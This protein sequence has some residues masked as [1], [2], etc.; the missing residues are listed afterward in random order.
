MTRLVWDQSG[1]KRYYTGLDR[2]VLY[3]P[4]GSAV[5]WN[6]LIAVEEDSSDI[7]VESVYFD[8][9]KSLDTRSSGDYSGSIKA[10]TYPE[11]FEQFD[12]LAEIENGV[13]LANQP[14]QDTFCLSYRTLIGNDLLGTAYGY[15]IH[16]VYNITATPDN[17]SYATLTSQADADELGWSISAVPEVVPGHRPTAHL[18]FDTTKLNSFLV[19]DIENLLYG[20]DSEKVE[21]EDDVLD[22]GAPVLPPDDVLG[23]GNEPGNLDGGT[24]YFSSSFDVLDGGSPISSITNGSDKFTPKAP[25]GRLP[26]M[27]E[28]LEMVTKWTLIDIVDNGDGTWTATGPDEL[29]TMTD[30]STFE[31]DR[32]AAEYLD[33]YTY[34]ITTAHGFEGG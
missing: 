26:K 11:E 29:I 28:L 27:S 10:Y 15:K 6:G 34:E 20:R 33:A 30:A 9:V 25:D 19:K 5:P 14:V 1:E 22:G 3:L 21:L 4:D 7:A 13:L 8:G 17:H 18:I 24:A 12:G 32:A 16:V 31:I 2:G 23:Q